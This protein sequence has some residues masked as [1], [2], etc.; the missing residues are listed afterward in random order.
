MK[1]VETLANGDTL[2][3]TTTIT[4]HKIANIEKQVTINV[5]EAGNPL[6]SLEGYFKLSESEPVK[7]VETLANGDT[8]TTYTITV[9]YHKIQ[10]EDKYVTKHVD[11]AGNELTDLTS[12]RKISE[13]EPIK[14]VE[15]LANGDTIT[16]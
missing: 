7:T 6:T 9:T 3:T 11:E 16:T 4:Y 15:T 1:T 14:T 12:Y 8:V 10:N 2:T 5:D 13:S